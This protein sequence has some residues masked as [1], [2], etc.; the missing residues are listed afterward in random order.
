M[1]IT[2][3]KVTELFCVIIFQFNHD[4]Q[5]LLFISFCFEKFIL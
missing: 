5:F 1:E 4:S 2:K 3:D